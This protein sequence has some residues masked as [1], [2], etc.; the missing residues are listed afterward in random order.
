MR[1]FVILLTILFFFSGCVSYKYASVSPTFKTENAKLKS[2]KERNLLFWE[3]FSNKEF[4]KSYELEL[5]HLRFQKSLAWYKTFFEPNRKGYKITL[6]TIEAIDE[7][8]AIVKNLYEDNEG[9]SFTI[10]DKWVYV[11]EKW[12]HFFEFSKLPSTDKPF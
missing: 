1:H 2:L 7:H 5:P 9:N 8:R 4:D 3:Y 11:S 10:E 12:Y 6:M